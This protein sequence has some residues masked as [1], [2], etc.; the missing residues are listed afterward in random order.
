MNIKNV[1]SW[2][3]LFIF[4]FIYL[5]I[6]LKKNKIDIYCESNNY[7]IEISQLKKT[8]DLIINQNRNIRKKL[9]NNSIPK[10]IFYD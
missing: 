10:K 1:N 2:N 6:Q 8:K 3:I 7:K 4:Y 9:L 5:N